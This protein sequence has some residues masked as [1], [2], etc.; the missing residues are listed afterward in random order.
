MITS[1]RISDGTAD[2][3]GRTVG[4]FLRLFALQAPADKNEASDQ[5]TLQNEGPFPDTRKP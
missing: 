5:L 1:S 4:T 3:N 2:E